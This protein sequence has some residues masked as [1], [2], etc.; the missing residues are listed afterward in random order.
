MG[1]IINTDSLRE[2]IEDNRNKELMDTIESWWESDILPE[3]SKQGEIFDVPLGV[4]F[5][6]L[7]DVLSKNGVSIE[8]AG[9]QSSFRFVLPPL[10]P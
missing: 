5:S 3:I 9:G 4:S 7:K 1:V 2:A 8:L 10:A 6:E